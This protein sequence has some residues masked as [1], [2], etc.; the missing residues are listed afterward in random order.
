VGYFRLIKS[1]FFFVNTP[2]THSFQFLRAG[3]SFRTKAEP[4]IYY[5]FAKPMDEED[6]ASVEQRKVQ[7]FEEWKAARREELSQYQKQIAEQ[8]VANVEK[9]LERWQNARKVRNTN[10]NNNDMMNLQE[11]MDKELETHRLEHGPKTRKIPGGGGSNDD[12]DDVEDINVGEDDMMEDVLDVEEN[13]QRGDEAVK[14]PEA[15]SSGGSPPPDN[16]VH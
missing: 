6:T 11:T 3:F 14:L 7:I 5:S 12:E 1:V 13:G 8:Y 10:N 4:H 2:L 9:E 15:S 16:K